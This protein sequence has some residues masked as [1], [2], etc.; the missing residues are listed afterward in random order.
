MMKNDIALYGNELS[1]DL[2]VEG[3][4]TVRRLFAEAE[5]GGVLFSP[6]ALPLLGRRASRLF[7]RQHVIVI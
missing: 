4:K 6:S 1:L 2:G 5:A 3:L 7:S